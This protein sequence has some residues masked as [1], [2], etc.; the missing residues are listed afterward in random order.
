MLDWLYNSVSN[1]VSS[2]ATTVNE[3]FQ[4]GNSKEGFQKDAFS[5]P[6]V[7]KDLAEEFKMPKQVH[8]MRAPV[9]LGKP[10]VE[11]PK[12][13]RTEEF[14]KRYLDK[15]EKS[16]IYDDV[17]LP[18]PRPIIPIPEERTKP[19]TMDTPASII[20]AEM[21]TRAQKSAASV[22]EPATL[23]L[24]AV[25]KRLQREQKTLRDAEKQ[26][27][28][29][30]KSANEWDQRSRVTNYLLS[31]ATFLTG[32][33]FMATGVPA[34]AILM[35]SSGGSI[36]AQ[37][38]EDYGVDKNIVSATSIG[39]GL[40]SLAGG[41]HSWCYAPQRFAQGMSA[42]LST[43]A[44]LFSTIAGAYQSYIGCMKNECLSEVMKLEALHTI[45]ETK[46]KMLLDKLPSTTAMFQNSTKSLSS[47]IKSLARC[48][49]RST[50]A[51]R[52][53]MAAFPA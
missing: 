28:D 30:K 24:D 43:G 27:F 41:I 15:L 37:V 1:G 13:V 26:A 21:M 38:M 46:V 25:E 3:I 14:E 12:V 45:T 4:P 31:G 48:H 20:I 42:V 29:T 6:Q 9:S 23:K 17:E 50:D 51:F 40:L 7:V 47:M 36:A 16:P 52:M 5:M 34:G 19:F 18:F 32:A 49:K 11:S 53:V 44:T 10:V 8:E 35:A 2:L 39:S 22:E 33:G